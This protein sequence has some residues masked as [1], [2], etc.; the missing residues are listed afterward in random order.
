MPGGSKASLRSV[1]HHVDD[2]SS[3]SSPFEVAIQTMDFRYMIEGLWRA[4]RQWEDPLPDGLSSETRY[5]IDDMHMLTT[6]QLEAY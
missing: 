2:S 5:W 3:G 6:L 4:N 1:R